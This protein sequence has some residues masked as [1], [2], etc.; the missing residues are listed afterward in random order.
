MT[1]QE[2]SAL[3]MAAIL[4]VVFGGYFALVVGE[5]AATPDR[6]VAYT[7][8]LAGVAV[9]VTI[10]A[11]T[12]HVVLALLFRSQANA[13]DERDRLI[14]LRSERLAGYVLALG[15]WT[16]IGLAMAQVDAFWIAQ[17]L[18]GSLVAAEVLE[19]IVKVT[20][21]RRGV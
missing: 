6:D 15:V 13:H 9:V 11:A 1:F 8:L 14:E 21:Y 10:L 3:T 5:I 17:A 7:G 2:K 16:G 18:I 12:S 4:V 19:G 20:L